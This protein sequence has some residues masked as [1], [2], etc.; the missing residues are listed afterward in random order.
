M[1][2]LYDTMSGAGIQHQI[3][4]IS[5]LLALG[6]AVA[7]FSGAGEDR[8]AHALVRAVNAATGSLAAFSGAQL[9]AGLVGTS[10]AGTGAL[11]AMTSACCALSACK[12]AGE[13]GQ[14]WLERRARKFR[15]RE[16]VQ[17]LFDV[18]DVEEV[19]FDEALLRRT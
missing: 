8:L 14:R 2:V 17:T 16:A 5:S 13:V 10:A 19:C 15:Y 4:A 18:D 7:G 6:E 11:A 12:M 1:G 9:V 3:L